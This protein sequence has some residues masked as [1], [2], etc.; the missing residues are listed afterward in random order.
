MI[1]KKA[2]EILARDFVDPDSLG[3][4]RVAR[5]QFNEP[6]PDLQSDVAGYTRELLKKCS[7]AA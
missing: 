5:F 1:T 7:K 2:I 6:N 4:I 3:P